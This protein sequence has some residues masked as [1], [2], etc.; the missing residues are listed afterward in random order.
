MLPVALGDKETGR[1]IFLYSVFLVALTALPAALG[2]FGALYLA[3]ALA[4]GVPF[5]ASPQ[6]CYRSW[7]GYGR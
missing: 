3:T 5:V 4:L 1:Q 6:S 2:L 7:S